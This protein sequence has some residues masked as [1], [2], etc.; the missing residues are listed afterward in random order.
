MFVSALDVAEANRVWIQVASK[1]D[2]LN[3]L[4]DRVSNLYNSRQDARYRARR[5]GGGGGGGDDDDDDDKT[6]FCIGDL[7]AAQL[8]EYDDTKWFR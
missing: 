5:G 4:N 3:E 6:S 8:M 1:A 7:V 2:R